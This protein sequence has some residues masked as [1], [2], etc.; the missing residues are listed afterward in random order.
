MEKKM[1]NKFEFK[2]EKTKILIMVIL[3]A[4]AC[5]LTYYFHAVLGKGTVFTHFFYIPIILSSL[6]W[7]R[8]GIV[9]TIFLIAILIFSHFLLRTDVETIN[10]LIRAPM[11]LIIAIVTAI[12]SEK[13]LKANERIKKERNF[14]ANV[15]ASVPDSLIVLDRHL[16]INKVNIS[17]KNIFGI[18]PENAAGIHITDILGD[19]DG[20]LTSALS[21]LIGTKTKIENFELP[22]NSE[23]F[24]K[25]IFNISARGIV[26]VEKN[27]N[28]YENGEEILIIIED[29]TIRKQAEE[30]LRRFNE[31]LE[32][33]VKER[34]EELSKKIK[35]IEAQRIVT[36][37]ISNDL[38]KTNVKLLKEVYER[39]S[40]E[41][42]LKKRLHE[43]EIFYDATLGREGRII[44]LKHQ[45]N[46]LLVQ[47]GKEKEYNV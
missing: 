31:E 7:K 37:N 12:L 13:I 34:T 47:L 44:E 14:S 24:D 9:V 10:D 3:L 26:Q 19:K 15:I 2:N 21:Q 42:E 6:W 32:Q 4:G 46:E 40:A 33:K 17:F 1:K 29:I 28:N 45:V 22:Y 23:K 18:E 39:K 36:V 11:F 8:K 30:T 5:F 27:G 41:K 20:K 25:R 43:L 35:E 16:R 38:E